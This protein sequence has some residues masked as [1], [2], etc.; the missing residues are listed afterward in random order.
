MYKEKA[1]AH[2]SIKSGRKISGA[3]AAERESRHARARARTV[4]LR[5]VSENMKLERGPPGRRGGEE[6]RGAPS[7]SAEVTGTHTEAHSWPACSG[8]AGAHARPAVL[9]QRQME[10]LGSVKVHQI[11]CYCPA[12]PWNQN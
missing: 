4:L 12:A 7:T 3:A 11:K 6:R 1:A 8:A 9:G 10:K 5:E 2:A